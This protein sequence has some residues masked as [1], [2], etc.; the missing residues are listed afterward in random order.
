MQFSYHTLTGSVWRSQLAFGVHPLSTASYTRSHSSSQLWCRWH[1]WNGGIQAIQGARPV[2]TATG[3]TPSIT[4]GSTINNNHDNILLFWLCFMIVIVILCVCSIAWLAHWSLSVHFDQCS[5]FSSFLALELSSPS[6]LSE[7]GS[8][9]L[10]WLLLP[11]PSFTAASC[12]ASPDVSSP[13][14]TSPSALSFS[15]CSSLLSPPSCC[16]EGGRGRERQGGTEEREREREIVLHDIIDDTSFLITPD[17]VR[18]KAVDW[19]LI[20]KCS[21]LAT[22]DIAVWYWIF[23]KMIISSLNMARYYWICCHPKS[24]NA[25]LHDFQTTSNTMLDNSLM[26]FAT[27]CRSK[28]KN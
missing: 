22:P 26:W 3:H 15:L 12:T 4:S 8:G 19:G 28:L 9:G 7:D 23:L 2:S 1:V 6:P 5:S 16:E 17:I 14:A 21:W 18:L 10:D 27:L 20:F 25:W 11:P 24:I 13:T